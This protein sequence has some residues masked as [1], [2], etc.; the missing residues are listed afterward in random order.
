MKIKFSRF[1]PALELEDGYVILNA[2]ESISKVEDLEEARETT[3]YPINQ[4]E[5]KHLYS[6]GNTEDKEQFVTKLYEKFISKQGNETFLVAVAS[7]LFD[8]RI[9]CQVDNNGPYI[10]MQNFIIRLNKLG[11]VVV[12]TRDKGDVLGTTSTSVVELLRS[13]SL[14]RRVLVIQLADLFKTMNNPNLC[15]LLLRTDVLYTFS[16][17]IKTFTDAEENERFIDEFE[18]NI[19]K[20]KSPEQVNITF[21]KGKITINNNGQIIVI[22]GGDGIALSTK[23][24]KLIIQQNGLKKDLINLKSFEEA[25]AKVSAKTV[26]VLKPCGKKATELYEMQIK[27]KMAQLTKDI[28]E[29]QRAARQEKH[30]QEDPYEGHK[31]SKSFNKK[32]K[33]NR[34]PINEERQQPDNSGNT[35]DNVK[36][37]LLFGGMIVIVILLLI[38]G[39]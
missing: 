31:P 7:V 4:E 28:V 33:Q 8:K 10:V 34:R 21:D 18:K 24:G 11:H 27:P 37:G 35:I 9:T 22:D 3:S 25:I 6:Q 13:S 39:N 32:I 30:K 16:D 17:F 2:L 26:A 5:Y 12:Y 19:L 23:D 20:D 29:E 14:P 36:M 38:I 1:G 15:Y